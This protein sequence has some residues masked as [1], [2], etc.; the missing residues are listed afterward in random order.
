MSSVKAAIGLMSGTSMDGVDAALLYT[1][2][3]RIAGFGPALTVPYSKEQRAQIRDAIA[4][5]ASMTPSPAVPDAF[6]ALGRDLAAWHANAI[7]LLLADAGVAAGDVDAVGFH[8]HTIRH[9]PD[10]GLTWQ[11]GDGAHLA[12][13]TGIPVVGNFRS[14]DVAAGGEGAPFAPLYHAALLGSDA[15]G[16]TAPGDWPV[17]ILNL[18]GV[19]NVTWVPARGAEDGLIAFDTG[20]GNALIDDWVQARTEQ[21]HDE[22]GTL[23]AT[24]AVDE[25]LI[26]EALGHPYFARAVPK[27]L[28]REDFASLVRTPAWQALGL[29]DGA[30]TLTALT[31]AT[32]VRAQEHFPAPP[33]A[34][35]VCGGGR[36]NRTLMAMLQDQLAVP[37]EPV[38]TLGWRGDHLE[39]EAFAHLAVRSLE[40]L[41]LSLPGTTGVSAP[42][43]GGRLFAPPEQAQGRDAL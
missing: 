6:A 4:M 2:G 42:L 32:V 21:A 22:G 1:D 33:L 12:A 41:P 3:H 34:W 10:R 23:A 35:Y 40:G 17:A 9:A 18:G 13:L 28:D 25:A 19:G 26:E 29:E 39:A 16:L 31:A 14:A 24:G 30:A 15:E 7:E 8:G 27:S 38:E 5:A 11:A 43:S 37:V 36:H 20:P